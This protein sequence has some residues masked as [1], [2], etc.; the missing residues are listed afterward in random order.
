MKPV[1]DPLIRFTDSNSLLVAV[2]GLEQLGREIDDAL[3]QPEAAPSATASTMVE[4]PRFDLALLGLVSLGERLQS[5]GASDAAVSDLG[6]TR[7]SVTGSQD[8]LR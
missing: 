3:P 8:L 7:R 6:P 5:L 1:T 4:A 2:L